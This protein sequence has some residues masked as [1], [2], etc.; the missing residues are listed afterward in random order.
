[1]RN[2][3]PARTQMQPR[4]DN[5]LREVAAP[6]ASGRPPSRWDARMSAMRTR[7]R[8]D[9]PYDWLL[10]E[11]HGGRRRGLLGLIHDR[12]M[13][14]RLDEAFFTRR[15]SGFARNH[16]NAGC[17]DH[18]FDLPVVSMWNI[19]HQRSTGL[20]GAFVLLLSLL[21]VVSPRAASPVVS[22]S[23]RTS[24]A[25]EP[26]PCQL[27]MRRWRWVPEPPLHSGCRTAG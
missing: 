23:K 10:V 15:G 8:V 24:C 7:G 2:D 21:R 13:R 27:R 16:A 19:A 6:T 1:M 26:P 22:R 18:V 17:L 9:G 12:V 25:D 5:V 3:E 11:T 4:L 14:G 20:A